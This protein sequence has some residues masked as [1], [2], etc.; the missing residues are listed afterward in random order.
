MYIVHM[1]HIHTLQGTPVLSSQPPPPAIHQSARMPPPPPVSAG[2]PF[3]RPPT[4]GA[5]VYHGQPRPHGWG[6]PVM[7][8][9]PSE[10]VPLNANPLDRTQVRVVLVLCVFL[11]SYL[12]CKVNGNIKILNPIIM[13]FNLQYNAQNSWYVL[14]W[15]TTRNSHYTRSLPCSTNYC[16]RLVAD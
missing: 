14:Y 4:P 9:P 16:N 3:Y 10:N 7:M 11:W 15:N 5:P 13:F 6:G 2:D 1:T 8:R 12:L